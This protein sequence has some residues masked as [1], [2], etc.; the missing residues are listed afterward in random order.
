LQCL[1]GP[2]AE[3]GAGKAE[4]ARAE[5]RVSL[6]LDLGGVNADPGQRV[7]GPLPSGRGDPGC[8]PP[9]GHLLARPG[10]LDA[11][12]AEHFACRT[13]VETSPGS[14]GPVPMKSCPSD[15]AAS[16]DAAMARLASPRPALTTSVVNVQAL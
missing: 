2:W 12:L 11:V 8:R 14:K 10:Q 1:L 16:S 5:G 7:A 15:T 9:P 3:G 4:Y 13:P 6:T